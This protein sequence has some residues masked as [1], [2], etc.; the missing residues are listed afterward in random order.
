MSLTAG[1]EEKSKRRGSRLF[2]RMVGSQS[3]AAILPK[4]R[5]AWTHDG[6]IR[7]GT[8]GSSDHG[9][10][11]YPCCHGEMDFTFVEAHAVFPRIVSGAV[12]DE[13]IVNTADIVV[14]HVYQPD[15]CVWGWSAREFTQ[16]FVATESELVSI[17]LLV[18]SEPGTFRAALVEGGLGGRQ[19]GRAKTFVSGHSM[20]WGHVRWSAGE[21]PLIPGRTYGI[22]VRREDGSAWTPY[23]HST[24]NAYDD[25]LLYVDGLPRPESELAVWI[26]EEPADLKRAVVQGADRGGWILNSRSVAFVPRTPN[27]RLITLTAS[28][29]TAEDMRSGYC[30]MVIHV[31]DSDGRGCVGPKRCL[32]VGPEGG[33]QTAHFLFASGE[34]PVRQGE[35]YEIQACLIP[36]T[37]EDLPQD[38]ERL[39][40]PRDLR[41]RVYGDAAAGVTPAI[42]NLRVRY[43]SNSGFRS[44]ARL[45]LSW[46][47]TIPC[48]KTIETWG[49]GVNDGARFE[50]EPGTREIEMV[51]F[52]PGHTYQFRMSA[53]GSTGSQW[54]TPL[55]EVR[56][57][58]LDEIGP[59]RQAEYPEQ[60]VTLAPPNLCAAPSYD[61]LRYVRGVSIANHDFEDG[62]E[63]WESGGDTPMGVQ[64]A[65][66]GVGVKWGRK[67]AGW[68]AAADGQRQQVLAKA[69][70]SQTIPTQP[71]NTYVLSVWARTAA[72]R[73]SR[74]NTRFRLFAD[75]DG[76]VTFNDPHSS[77]WYW[78]DGLWMRFQHRWTADADRTTIGVGLFRWWDADG[79]TAVV[80]HVT[81]YDL[82][83]AGLQAGDPRA[84]DDSHPIPA[85]GLAHPK[86][87]SRDKVE[88]FLRAPPGYVITG[89]GSRAQDDNITTMWLRVQPLL[90][91]GTLG[92]AEEI[93]GG[94]E[95]DSSLEARVELPS[96]Y[97]A[98]GFGAAVAPEWDVKRFRVWGRPLLPG[99]T[100]GE[101]K[102]FRGGADL[103]SGVEREVRLEPG[104]VLTAAGL[105]CML[106]DV[107]GI[108][109]ESAAVVRSATGRA[110]R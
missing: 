95:P 68:V 71:G 105:N 72:E 99:G 19:I 45:T 87:E 5:S 29:V 74:G 98:T 24:G 13:S 21:V 73:K 82:G 37:Q 90:P 96:G 63:G 7:T 62:L 51:K 39:I 27:I 48:R 76:A 89:I 2:F 79:S 11:E 40:V 65:A 49:D 97:V 44:D 36:H 9:F 52:W 106:N 18:A 38:Y 56:I 86:L 57:P 83:P 81:V 16:T 108:R 69:S 17:T 23:L 85:V 41:A 33:A 31:K 102:E 50:V 12:A 14:D 10:T 107:N 94:W 30:D 42:Y 26:V 78:T 67:M 34:F 109:A 15:G 53:V 88:A 77:Q 101:E 3:N 100:L 91:D 8:T 6:A 64:D 4:S 47:E 80:D 104:R 43:A 70:L 35:R 20:Q 103:V 66:T 22:R 59:I 84:R 60:F 46:S 32:A 93:R 58:R 61:A 75:S 54:R 110:D 28:P 1:G 55:Y 25:G 92:P